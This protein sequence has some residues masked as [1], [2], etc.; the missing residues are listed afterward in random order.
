VFP[1]LITPLD[2]I[3]FPFISSWPIDAE[4]TEVEWIFYGPP[5]ESP[6]QEKTWDTFIQIFDG[7][8]N[9]DFVNLA[10]MQRSIASGALESIRLS[11]QERRIYHLHEEID[12]VI[13]REKV[14]EA[15]RVPSLLEPF[16][17][18]GSRMG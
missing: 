15:L 6:Q 18:D 8:M 4:T 16:W 12:R 10:P 17:E 9:E 14:P 5:A 2:T 1:N 7:V 11:Y 13:G 3:G